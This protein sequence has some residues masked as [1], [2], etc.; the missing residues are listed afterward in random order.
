MSTTDTSVLSKL[1]ELLGMMTEMKTKMGAQEEELGAQKVK[2]EELTLSNAE[3]KSSISSEDRMHLDRDSPQEKECNG[4]RFEW[5]AWR[6]EAR[7]KLNTNGRAISNDQEQIGYL[8]MHLQT[9]A[10]KRIQQWYNMCLKT[11]T[12]CNPM[13]FLERAKGTFGNPN[14]KKNARTL[15]SAT[16]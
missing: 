12:N 1:E 13:E 4:E 14:E 9:G 3:R 7:T 6:T 10:Q 16:K 15:L 2:I 11:N 8:Y 5:I